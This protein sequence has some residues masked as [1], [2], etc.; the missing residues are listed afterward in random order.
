MQ[1][2]KKMNIIQPVDLF[3]IIFLSV[4]L[5]CA[6]LFDFR[7]Q[8]IPNLLTL[9]A[10]IFSFG[11]HAFTNGFSGFLFSV[12]G[13]ALGIGL[14]II[15]Y[16]LGGMG[17]G[18]AKLMGVVGGVLGA[19]GVFCAFLFSALIGGI[20]ALI[21]T[22]IYRRHFRGFYK[23]QLTVLKNFLLIRKYIPD[24]EDSGPK[25]PRLC[26]GLAIA[27]GT[28]IYIIFDLSGYGLLS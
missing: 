7:I 14:L 3:L 16:L 8:K 27:L 17:A 6:G 9:P 25:K 5:V 2:Y 20:Y 15:P 24:P 13:L 26:Y 18:D 22:L 21:L 12:Q 19:K 4:V 10:A 23:K 28:G 11:Y 1:T